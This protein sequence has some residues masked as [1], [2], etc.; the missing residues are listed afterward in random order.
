M[1]VP[2]KS[3]TYIR[4]EITRKFREDAKVALSKLSPEHREK[5]KDTINQLYEKK[6]HDAI[7]KVEHVIFHST[8]ASGGQT[9]ILISNDEVKKAFEILDK[10]HITKQEYRNY[11]R[12]LKHKVQ[13][14]LEKEEKLK[15][16]TASL[17]KKFT[18]A[19]TQPL[20][21]EAPGHVT[22]LMEKRAPSQKTA[23]AVPGQRINSIQQL[24]DLKRTQTPQSALYARTQ[25]QVKPPM[26]SPQ[27]LPP[28][29]KPPASKPGPG[30]LANLPP[31]NPLKRAA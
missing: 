20:P 3:E 15:A 11:F 5:Q 22:S 21:E 2:I 1:R 29:G 9:H 23:S 4:N 17:G 18:V 26:A 28:A 27:P 24:R 8:H 12:G 14:D 25:N 19:S 6:A 13:A 7:H 31:K 16:K 10:A 30:L